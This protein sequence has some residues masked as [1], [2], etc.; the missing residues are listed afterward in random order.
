MENLQK[1]RELNMEYQKFKAMD[2]ERFRNRFAEKKMNKVSRTAP[3]SVEEIEAQN[4]NVNSNNNMEVLLKR[5]DVLQQNVDDLRKSQSKANYIQDNIPPFPIN[6]CQPD[7]IDDALKRIYVLED[8]I[9]AINVS[10]NV[11]KTEERSEYSKM[12]NVFS[13]ISGSFLRVTDEPVSRDRSKQMMKERYANELKLQIEEKQRQKELQRQKEREEDLIKMSETLEYDTLGHRIRHKPTGASFLKANLVSPGKQ[14][15]FARGGN[16]IF[17]D[18]LT[19]SQKIANLNYRNELSLQIEEKRLREEKRRQEEKELELKELQ[20]YFNEVKPLSC[21]KPS[22]S[23]Q[24]IRPTEPSQVSSPPKEDIRK[25]SVFI[26]VNLERQSGR[27]KAIKVFRCVP[28]KD[29]PRIAPKID[30]LM[31]QITQLKVELNAEKLRME[32]NRTE[33]LD[34]IHVYDPRSISQ[35]TTP[36]RNLKRP[37]KVHRLMAMPNKINAQ[38]RPDHRFALSSSSQ[39][40]P[41]SRHDT[42]SQSPSLGSLNLDEIN[43][44][45]KRRF[46]NLK[47]NE[48]LDDLYKN[49][50]PIIRDFMAKEEAKLLGNSVYFI[51]QL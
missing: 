17:G 29:K 19:E 45:M 23:P 32:R 36:S 27:P 28:P 13:T 18:P 6:V 24:I 2:E 14:E 42:I 12:D 40:L 31:T 21:P 15:N 33:T 25:Q 39:F 34:V 50:P 5:L 7:I 20:S 49:E 44:Q 30:E 1:R 46:E 9:K 43:K 41:Q 10:E 11:K 37:I 48:S 22:E 8:V 26:Q 16:G 3:E 38:Q 47:I 51:S 35:H 4:I